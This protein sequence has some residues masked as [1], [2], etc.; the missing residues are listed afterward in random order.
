MRSIQGRCDI[1]VPYAGGSYG[2]VEKAVTRHFVV[3]WNADRNNQ[4]DLQ[5]EQLEADHLP[6]KWSMP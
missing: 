6:I 4:R 2:A 1:N 5:F 3:T